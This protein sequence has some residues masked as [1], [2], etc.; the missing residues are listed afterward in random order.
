MPLRRLPARPVLVVLALSSAL[1]TGCSAGN[2]TVAG[3]DPVVPVPSPSTS[4]VASAAPSPSP[5]LSPSPSVRVITATYAGGEV[6]VDSSRVETSL[7]EQVVLRISSDV[8]EEVHV[9]GYDVYADVPAGGSVD[10]PLTLT[11]PGSFEV[12]LHEAGR[13]LFQLRTA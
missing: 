2:E 3:D 1:L 7:G 11:L 5:S 9:H 10:I 8:L 6:Q 12:E 4:A 13:P